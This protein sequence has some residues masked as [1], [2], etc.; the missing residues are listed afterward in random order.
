MQLTAVDG[1]G[2]LLIGGQ[3]VTDSLRDPEIEHGVSLVAKVPAIRRALVHQQRA[4]A[5]DG[6]I[7]VI[8][9]DI[10][11]VVMPKAT[12]KVYLAASVDVR[13][14]RRYIELERR[15][16]SVDYAQVVM[17]LQRRD[18]IDS[19]RADS[20]LRPAEDATVID[21]EGLGVEDLAHQ[22]VGLVGNS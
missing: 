10:G 8:G 15:G 12:I 7:I 2:R 14:R 6:P 20:P 5:R 21:T 9:R 13:A 19:G 18:K 22:I 16:E 11:T 17:E 3:D 1:D 4:I